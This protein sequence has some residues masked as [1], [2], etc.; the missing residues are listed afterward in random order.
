MR[1]DC[2]VSRHLQGVVSKIVVT[3]QT[4]S[5]SN[6]IPRAIVQEKPLGH[7]GSPPL[8]TLVVPPT[9]QT[10][11]STCRQANFNLFSMTDQDSAYEQRK[12]PIDKINFRTND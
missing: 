1:S 7:S 9:F 11:V 12:L 5:K 6:Q 4:D 2:S 10:D 3:A 8:L